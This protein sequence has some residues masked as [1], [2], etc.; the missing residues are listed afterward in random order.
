MDL[1]SQYLKLKEYREH[2]KGSLIEKRSTYLS[3]LNQLAAI[4]LSV[5]FLYKKRVIAYDYVF[6]LF[7]ICKS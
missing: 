1:H 3:D 6:D 2:F 5:I 4:Q 7:L